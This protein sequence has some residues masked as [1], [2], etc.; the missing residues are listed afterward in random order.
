V[1]IFKSTLYYRPNTVAAIRIKNNGNV[2]RTISNI[3]SFVLSISTNKSYDID[4]TG[5]SHMLLM[6]LTEEIKS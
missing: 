5:F 1:Y 6:D 4:C 3:W 2:A